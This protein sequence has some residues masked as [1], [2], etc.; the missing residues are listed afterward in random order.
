VVQY[1]IVAENAVIESGA[2]VGEAPEAMDDSSKWGVA[3]IGA[4]VTVGEGA[5]VEPKTMAG[6]DVPAAK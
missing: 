6:E 3:V 4:G 2:V 1:S 5:K